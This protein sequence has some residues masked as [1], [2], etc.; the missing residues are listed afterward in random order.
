L[1]KNGYQATRGCVAVDE[2]MMRHI[3]AHISLETMINITQ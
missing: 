1:E 2:A 3:L